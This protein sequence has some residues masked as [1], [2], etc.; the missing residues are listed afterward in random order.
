VEY[1]IRRGLRPLTLAP[2]HRSSTAVKIQ[3]LKNLLQPPQHNAHKPL[4]ASPQRLSSCSRSHATT[5]LVLHHGY[6]S[7]GGQAFRTLVLRR[8]RD[9]QQRLNN[10]PVC[11]QNSCTR[12]LAHAQ[13]S[14]RLPCPAGVTGRDAARSKFAP[15]QATARPATGRS[16]PRLSLPTAPQRHCNR[17]CFFDFA[18]L[19]DPL[20][21]KSTNGG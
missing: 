17:R 4:L 5:H 14:Q 20:H 3:S 12:R 7:T 1:S 2:Q 21:G 9:H 19:L 16:L 13:Q 11:T 8:Y 10:A 6:R 18:T 15:L